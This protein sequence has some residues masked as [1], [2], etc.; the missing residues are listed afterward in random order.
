MAQKKK[1]LV[2]LGAGSSRLLDSNGISQ[3]MPSVGEL[4]H[5]MRAWAADLITGNPETYTTDAIIHK[6]T[7]GKP[8]YYEMA[9]K[10]REAYYQDASPI[11]EDIARPNYERVLGDLHGF[12]NGFLTK[13]MGDPLLHWL[14]E[15]ALKA[16]VDFSNNNAFDD[17]LRQI[18][19]LYAKLARYMR[20][21]SLDF[22]NRAANLPQF[23][24][25]A[26]LMR[27]LKDY[28]E[29]GVYTLNYD[30]LALTALPDFFTGFDTSTN[31]GRFQPS[32]VHQ[33]PDWNFIYH[34]H[35]SVHHS[36][37]PIEQ[38]P[39]SE[40]NRSPIV[41]QPK[42]SDHFEEDGG[43]L[44]SATDHR[45]MVPTTLIAGGWKLDQ[46]QEDPFQTLY[47]ALPRHA[48]EADAVLVGGYGFGDAQINSVL[49]AMLRAQTARGRRP[50]VLVLGKGTKPRNL[51]QTLIGP[52]L[53]GFAKVG[54]DDPQFE[55]PTGSSVPVIVWS[56]GFEQASV[57]LAEIIQWLDG[58]PQLSHEANQL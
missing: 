49:Q 29:L 50:P 18:K 24:S 2:L 46:I 19:A 5:E 35:G 47:S 13:P 44:R 28:F 12:M 57:R 41:W 45:R 39:Q 40:R 54:L 15:N 42:L 20:Q 14:Q 11:M 58:R 22:E 55:G 33:C 56:E 8:N 1:L 31:Q 6:R 30:T 53:S 25:Y 16:L 7:A 36:F 48:H 38:R 17:I 26:T 34:L 27:G 23:V 37:V 21:R 3:G 9:L 52:G 51:S 10:N 43:D 32:T 4:D